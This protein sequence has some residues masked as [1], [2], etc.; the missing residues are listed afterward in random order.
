MQLLK[1]LSLK[2]LTGLL[3]KVSPLM[4]CVPGLSERWRSSP[5]KS[6]AWTFA[7]PGLL[8]SPQKVIPERIFCRYNNLS[9]LY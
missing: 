4:S 2:K 9:L 5:C 1:A 3:F 7:G 6:E 8:L